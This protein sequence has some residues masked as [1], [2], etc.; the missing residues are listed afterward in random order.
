[1]EGLE[2]FDFDVVGVM[3]R[4]ILTVDLFAMPEPMKI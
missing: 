1:V 2:L 4:F 3:P